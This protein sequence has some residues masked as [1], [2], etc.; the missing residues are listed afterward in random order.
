MSINE[1]LSKSQL[2]ILFAKESGLDFVNQVDTSGTLSFAVKE[3]FRLACPGKGNYLENVGENNIHD[4]E[5]YYTGDKR[6]LI[7]SVEYKF[8]KLVYSFLPTAVTQ[9][10]EDNCPDVKALFEIGF[11]VSENELLRI[12]EIC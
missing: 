1:D 8:S 10:M 4:I 3:K 12:L 5:A 11:Q 6:F 9:P 2:L 7:N